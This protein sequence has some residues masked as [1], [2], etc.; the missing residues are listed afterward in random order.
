MKIV[1]ALGLL[2]LADCE[3]S[4]AKA[5][6]APVVSAPSAT[7]PTSAAPSAAATAITTAAPA[8]SMTAAPIA[9]YG[10]AASAAPSSTSTAPKRRV[11]KQGEMCAG[12]AGIGCD[13]GLTCKMPPGKPYPDQSGVCAGA[14]G[15]TT[16][17]PSLTK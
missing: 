11:A 3:A 6:D 17:L 1:L 9:S 7:S 10:A 5:P 14:D 8:A 4:T 13:T 15:S 16:K 12:F 2:A